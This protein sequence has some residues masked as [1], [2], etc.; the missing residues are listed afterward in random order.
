MKDFFISILNYLKSLVAIVI[1]VLFPLSLLLIAYPKVFDEIIVFRFFLISILICFFIMKGKFKLDSLELLSVFTLLIYTQVIHFTL[2]AHES[3]AHLLFVKFS[4]L[5]LITSIEQVSAFSIFIIC[6]YLLILI[7]GIACRRIIKVNKEFSLATLN[8]MFVD[9][10][11]RIKKD[12]LSEEQALQERNKI[13]SKVEYYSECDGVFT[14]IFKC[15]ISFIVL[16]IIHFLAGIGSDIYIQKI[17]FS[18]VFYANIPLAFGAAYPFF[19]LFIFFVITY[20]K[21]KSWR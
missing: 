8:T 11:N 15:M 12:E 16:T 6:S 14:T 18:E 7:P 4:Q 19:V 5:K 20:L 13:E 21:F 1:G 10:D 9:I 3:S 2:L 17:I